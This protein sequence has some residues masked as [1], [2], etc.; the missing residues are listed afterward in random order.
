MFVDN[1]DDLNHSY[2]II[3]KNKHQAV[4]SE[5]TDSNIVKLPWILII[6]PKIR[7]EL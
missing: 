4:K 7:K 6:G 1:G 2:S 5:N 3:R